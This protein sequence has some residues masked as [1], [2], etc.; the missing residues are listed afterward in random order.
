MQVNGCD[1]AGEPTENGE[2]VPLDCT[3]HFSQRIMSILIELVRS[4]SEQRP[5]RQRELLE[6][7]YFWSERRGAIPS[8]KNLL[9]VTPQC[10]RMRKVFP[11]S[12]KNQPFAEPGADPSRECGGGDAR[13]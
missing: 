12:M 11:V 1:V 5:G 13:G 3:A 10:P 2:V 6:S 9:V 4:N 7:N 8:K